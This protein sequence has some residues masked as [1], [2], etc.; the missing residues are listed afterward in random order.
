M[1]SLAWRLRTLVVAVCT[2]TASG[3][4]AV[5][6]RSVGASPAV[7]YDA[8]SEKGRKVF[9]APRGMPVEV[10]LSYGEWIKV[11]D[12]GG[13]L[14]WVET[15]ALVPKRMLM[16]T[17]VNGKLRAS[18]DDAAPVVLTA[19]RGVLLELAEPVV[20]GWIKARHRDGVTGFIKATDVWGD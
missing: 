6:F 5:D 9:V 2:L 16:V 17:A 14:A 8:P 13:D 19:D 7:M 10:V 20:S 1:I 11:R 4:H 18:A 12:A 3:A 15:R